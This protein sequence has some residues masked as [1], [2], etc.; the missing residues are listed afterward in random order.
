MLAP[1]TGRGSLE[2]LDAMAAA[3]LPD[4]GALN[5]KQQDL[6][7]REATAAVQA[8]NGAALKR[9]AKFDGRLTPPLNGFVPCAYGDGCE[10]S[11]RPASRRS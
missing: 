7:L 2:T 5:D 11:G 3:T 1:G 4:T 6:L 9:L 8:G 10:G